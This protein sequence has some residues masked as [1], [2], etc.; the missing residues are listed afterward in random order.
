MHDT[1]DRAV[2][3][4]ADGISGFFALCRQFR[5]IRRAIGSRESAVSISAAI[6][7]VIDTA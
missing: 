5:R 1:F 6:S 3:I 2:R 7:G 4:I